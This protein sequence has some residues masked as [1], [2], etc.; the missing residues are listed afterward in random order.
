[1]SSQAR[2]CDAVAHTGS[3]RSAAATAHSNRVRRV[4]SGRSDHPFGR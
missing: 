4:L 2:T 3:A 1:M